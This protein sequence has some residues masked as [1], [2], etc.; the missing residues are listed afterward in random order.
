MASEAVW[1]VELPAAA[2][3]LTEYWPTGVI[4]GDV[5]VVLAGFVDP[6]PA[7]PIPSREIASAN[8]ETRQTTGNRRP[9]F[10]PK[11]RSIR[12][13][14]RTEKAATAKAGGA[15]S[16]SVGA[17]TESTPFDPVVFSVS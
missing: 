7:I 16:R 11:D 6:Q 2:V 14:A 15:P 3:T 17:N 1:V 10:V 4:R 13:P 5:V 8:T 9:I 12:I